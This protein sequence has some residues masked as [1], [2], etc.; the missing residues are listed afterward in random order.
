MITTMTFIMV[1]TTLPDT[2]YGVYYCIIASAGFAFRFGFLLFFFSF[3]QPAW[4][5][6]SFGILVGSFG[7]TAVAFRFVGS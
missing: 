4:F 2:N 1:T 6:Y 7:L 3:A 5:A